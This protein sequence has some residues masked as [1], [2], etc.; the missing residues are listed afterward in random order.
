MI[1]ALVVQLKNTRNA[2][3]NM[4]N[5][6][7]I[8]FH[9]GCHNCTNQIT[10]GIDFCRLCQFF[11]VE[12]HKPNLNSA[13]ASEATIARAEVLDRYDKKMFTLFQDKPLWERIKLLFI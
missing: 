5:K 4:K 8:M 6:D 7:I 11:D 10:K 12:W 1:L 3:D 9:G 13:K 2:V